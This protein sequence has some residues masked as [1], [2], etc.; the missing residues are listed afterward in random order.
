MIQHYAQQ[1]KVNIHQLHSQNTF[2]AKQLQDQL[3]DPCLKLSL[4]QLAETEQTVL[5]ALLASWEQPTRC[6]D[7]FKQIA[8]PVPAAPFNPEQETFIIRHDVSDGNPQ[9]TEVMQDFSLINRNKDLK[10]E[11]DRDIS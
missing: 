2:K 4:E 5:T 6:A 8:P 1:V 3:D 11:S 9:I 7:L 10:E